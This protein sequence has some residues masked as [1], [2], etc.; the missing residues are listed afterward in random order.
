[1][2]KHSRLRSVSPCCC[3]PESTDVHANIAKIDPVV[4]FVAGT[5]AGMA[6][7]VIAFPFDTG[8]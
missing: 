5:L 6:G 8:K 1:M 7:L 2:M 3:L 4:D